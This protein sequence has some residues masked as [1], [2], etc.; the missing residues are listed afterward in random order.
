MQPARLAARLTGPQP[1]RS[2]VPTGPVEGRLPTGPVEG[3][4]ANRAGCRP[5]WQPARLRAGWPTGPVE[6]RL[7]NR[8]GPTGPVGTGPVEARLGKDPLENMLHFRFP[9]DIWAENCNVKSNQNR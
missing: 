8:P 1:A 4:L 6:G 9:L 2:L 7:A 5:G 3:R